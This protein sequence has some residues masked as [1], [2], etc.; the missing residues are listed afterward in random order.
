MGIPGQYNH[1][2]GS[3]EGGDGTE[4]LE[5]NGKAV[6]SLV[7]IALTLAGCTQDIYSA[8]PMADSHP[9]HTTTSGSEALTL[10]S[11]RADSQM[12]GCHRLFFHGV[13]TSHPLVQG[14]RARA[15]L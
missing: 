4:L 12:L 1:A 15:S 3:V 10:G 11:P 13:A 7:C 2:C 6:A 5:G 9:D 8:L 14:G